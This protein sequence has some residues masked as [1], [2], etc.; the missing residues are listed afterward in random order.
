MTTAV[1][2]GA[3]MTT[4]AVVAGVAMIITAVVAGEAMIITAVV[5]GAAMT[6]T[7]AVTAAVISMAVAAVVAATSMAAITAVATAT[8]NRSVWLPEGIVPSGGQQARWRDGLPS[9]PAVSFG[10]FKWRFDRR[11]PG[12]ARARGDAG[13]R[14]V[15]ASALARAHVG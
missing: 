13:F 6:T 12:R 15:G 3:A 5:A 9:V 2:A 8:I 7:A 4:T 14:A 1:V 10:W 11:L